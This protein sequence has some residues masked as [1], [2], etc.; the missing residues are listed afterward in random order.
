MGKILVA[1]TGFRNADDLVWIGPAAN[2]AAK[3]SGLRDEGIPL[4][5]TD[6][7][8]SQLA[9]EA[10]LSNGTD[11]WQLRTWKQYN[12]NIYCSRYRWKN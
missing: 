12:R 2:F 3:L 11:M 6:S 9:D 8:Y 1:R 4:W 10:K 7:V 5:I